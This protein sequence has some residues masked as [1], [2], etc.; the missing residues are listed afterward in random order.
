MTVYTL[1]GESL[2]A[3]NTVTR[4]QQ[5]YRLPV[6]PW[7]FKPVPFPPPV[8]SPVDIGAPELAEHAANVYRTCWK[9]VWGGDREK[10]NSRYWACMAV[11][12]KDD[13]AMARRLKSAL[14]E[15][16]DEG[17]NLSLL[18][19]VWW[20]MARAQDRGMD[21]VPP[22]SCFSPSRL[23]SKQVRGFFWRD[24]GSA[25]TTMPHVWTRAAERAHALFADFSTYNRFLPEGRTDLAKEVWEFEHAPELSRLAD[26]HV[27][28]Y[29]RIA[30][31]ISTRQWK[32]DIGLWIA[33]D[34]RDYLKIA[35]IS[36]KDLR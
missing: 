4:A 10:L 9:W 35:D 17:S 26:E 15:V 14:R 28:Q 33:A 6:W 21:G 13:W 20:E 29:D 11:M 31:A 23:T 16:K 24:C 8:Q 27:R 36:A 34:V 2:P 5:Q 25:L 7:K 19:F 18:I 32:Y 22:S 3:I 1:G 30:D 12:R